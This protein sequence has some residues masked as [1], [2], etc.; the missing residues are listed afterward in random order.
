MGDLRLGSDGATFLLA[1]LALVFVDRGG[2]EA[3]D[4]GD[5]VAAIVVAELVDESASEH[6][7]E[8]AFAEAEVVADVEMGKRVFVL[9]G[10]RQSSGVE[11][12]ALVA[13][14]QEDAGR[15]DP[16]GDPQGQV[17]DFAVSP[18]D[19]VASHFHDRLAEILD[20]TLGQR[21]MGEEV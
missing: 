4:E 14:G 21:G 18:L 7:A 5:F 17:G 3:F 12:G 15:V 1:L 8:A 20:L 13:D 10:V 6:D 2:G 9:G 16:I 19:R 11:A